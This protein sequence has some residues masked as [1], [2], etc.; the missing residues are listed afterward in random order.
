MFNMHGK[1]HYKFKMLWSTQN[2]VSCMRPFGKIKTKTNQLLEQENSQSRILWFYDSMIYCYNFQVRQTELIW[3]QYK[4]LNLLK[5]ID[6][7][8]LTP[9]GQ[10]FAPCFLKW[11]VW[12]RKMTSCSEFPHLDSWDHCCMQDSGWISPSACTYFTPF[13]LENMHTY[14]HMYIYTYMYLS[15]YI[16]N[17]FMCHY[18]KGLLQK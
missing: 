16:W 14:M 15:I 2:L 8:P 6:L 9:A 13:N 12:G 1:Q 18:V 7:S 11:A 4:Y 10:E 5:S 17:I 3:G